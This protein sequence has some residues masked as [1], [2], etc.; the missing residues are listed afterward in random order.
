MS[1]YRT[2]LKRRMH[3]HLLNINRGM[4]GDGQRDGGT[5]QKRY[6]GK[7]GLNVTVIVSEMSEE[8]KP[9]IVPWKESFQHEG[10]LEN[11]VVHIPIAGLKTTNAQQTKW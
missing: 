9:D 11:D 8:Q 2:T 5:R 7:L 4:D 3:G 6:Q 1:H 10:H